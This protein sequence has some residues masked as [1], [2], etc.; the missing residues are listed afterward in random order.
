MYFLSLAPRKRTRE[1][2]NQMTQKTQSTVKE[3]REA[4]KFWEHLEDEDLQ[5]FY[6][7]SKSFSDFKDLSFSDFIVASARKAQSNE[8]ENR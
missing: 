4:R 2:R 5:F 8:R 1:G 3:I 6:E 7:Q